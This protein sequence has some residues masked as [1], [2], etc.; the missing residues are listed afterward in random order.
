MDNNT[1][2][3][4]TDRSSTLAIHFTDWRSRHGEI[5]DSTT[6]TPAYTS[7]H[8]YGNPTFTLS[9][10]DQSTPL[11]TA[12]R[13]WFSKKSRLSI[14]GR[15]LELDPQYK[16][17]GAG[18]DVTYDSPAYGERTLKWEPQKQFRGV[19]LVCTDDQGQAVAQVGLESGKMGWGRLRGEV[20]FV[21]GMVETEAQRDELVATGL[22][23]AY[24]MVMRKKAATGAAAGA[25]TGGMA[26]VYA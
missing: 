15:E 5:L 10:A 1:K 25:G 26:G 4:T 7:E 23:L 12:D 17:G 3:P 8:R 24:R 6:G 13:P 14:A 11:A 21:E 2:P 16:W 22:C 20:E 19:R 18:G 9:G